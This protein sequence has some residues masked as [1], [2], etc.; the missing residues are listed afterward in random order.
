VREEETLPEDSNEDAVQL[1]AL[2]RLAARAAAQVRRMRLEAGSVRLRVCY[3]DGVESASAER[4]RQPGSGDL[5][6]RAVARRLLE[7][8]RVRRIQVRHLEL[9][10]ADLHEAA[11]QMSLFDG[12]G[13]AEEDGSRSRRIEAA[14]AEPEA[15]GVKKRCMGPVEGE[16]EAI[17]RQRR[18]GA[19]TAALDRLRDRFG[20][21]SV[22]FQ[23]R[24]LAVAD[25]RRRSLAGAEGS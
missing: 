10:L 17:R 20:A 19:L 4:S 25:R 5:A 9:T 11:G 24:P 14:P 2:D 13:G 15:H 23:P 12:R 21:T 3:A 7:K 6:V 22:G 18:D 8:V 1:E 16:T